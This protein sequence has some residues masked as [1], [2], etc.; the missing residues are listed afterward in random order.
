MDDQAARIAA[1]RSTFGHGAEIDEL[2]GLTV[3][4]PDGSWFNVR[5]SNTEPL[6]RLNVE[7]RTEPEMRELRDAV[8]AYLLKLTKGIVVALDPQLLELL[9]CPSDDHAPLREE[10]R[11]GTDV[12]GVLALRL[13]VP[14]RGRHPGPAARRGVPGPNGLGNAA[15]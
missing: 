7:A 12:L 8:R 13:G 14:H 11:D 4:R 6:L 15:E 2:D 3:S 1:V 10:T 9:A 5:A